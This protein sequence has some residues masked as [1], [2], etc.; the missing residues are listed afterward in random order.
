MSLTWAYISS[1]SDNKPCNRLAKNCGTIVSPKSQ[2]V[3]KKT[4]HNVSPGI[5]VRKDVK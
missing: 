1:T 2:Y 3:N 4:L 5:G